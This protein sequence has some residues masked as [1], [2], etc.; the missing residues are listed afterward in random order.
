M[1]GTLPEVRAGCNNLLQSFGG[2]GLMGS[3]RPN[4]GA[5]NL[6]DPMATDAKKTLFHF[7]VF[8]TL[9]S[10]RRFVR[11]YCVPR[12]IC[13]LPRKDLTVEQRRQAAKKGITVQWYAV[14]H[15][16]RAKRFGLEVVS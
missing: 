9:G 6:E 2:Y 7:P 1:A 13:L 16:A 5:M 11:G 8:E 10:A 3:W 15:P 14:M 4:P 12:V